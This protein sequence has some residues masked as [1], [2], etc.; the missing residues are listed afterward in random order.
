MAINLKQSNLYF[1]LN[2]HSVFIYYFLLAMLYNEINRV[3][4]LIPIL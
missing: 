2:F 1:N 4:T 3:V